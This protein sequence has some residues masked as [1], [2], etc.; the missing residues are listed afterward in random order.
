MGVC[1]AQIVYNLVDQNQGIGP[2][3][4]LC[5]ANGAGSSPCFT[6]V[7]AMRLKD[8]T[9]ISED[10]AWPAGDAEPKARCV[11]TIFNVQTYSIHDGPG[12][13]TTVFLK[14][15]PL[16]CTWCQ[17]PESQITKPE[18]FFNS[19]RCLGCGAC[20]AVCPEGAIRLVDGRSYT[21]RKQCKGHGACVEACPNAARSLMGRT[22]SADEVFAE[23]Q[24]DAIFYERSGGGVTLSGGE[25]LAQPRFSAELLRHC[26]NAGI[27]TALDTC[28][29]AKW[30]T[31]KQVL[32]HVDLVL[33]DFKH[34]DP[35][36]HQKYT[37]V[38]NELILEN[39]K[40]MHHELG[41]PILARV[42]LMPGCN[43]SVE[44]MTA[45]ARFIATELSPTVPVHLNA[46]HR[47][48]EAK[49]DRL[50]RR[51]GESSIAPPS[52][53]Y[54]DRMKAIFEW[55]GLTTHVGG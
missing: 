15:C 39:A 14:G 52:D 47:L 19:E 30:E 4:A 36:Q 9:K 11:G 16:R 12:I 34:M 42:P 27:H 54:V 45:T 8:S 44:N 40:R 17:N 23:V 50:E 24:S 20:A 21:D 48:G 2:G 13:R 28:G 46:Y 18:I 29:H 51:Y 22:V 32:Q 1:D 10:A 26:K 3:T 5:F 37:G 49:Y 7:R 33:L 31:A 25:P 53:E 38:S 6:S 55:F 41:I 43:D 35:V